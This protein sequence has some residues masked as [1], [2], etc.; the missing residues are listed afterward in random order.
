MQENISSSADAKTAETPSESPVV[1]SP[2]DAKNEGI[3]STADA[4]NSGTDEE[5]HP[6]VRAMMEA[7]GLSID[8]PKEETPAPKVE[9][10][11]PKEEPKEETPKEEQQEQ[12][13]YT[14]SR[15]DVR[16]AEKHKAY[17]ALLGQPIPNDETLLAELQGISKEEKEN[18][19]HEHLRE[20][21]RLRGQRPE[22]AQLDEDDI[23]AIRDEEREAIRREVLAEEEAKRTNAQKA[24][25]ERNFI[26]FIESHPE[27]VKDKKEF[28]ADLYQAVNALFTGGMRIDKAFETVQKQIEIARE[29][30]KKETE[31]R[32]ASGAFSGSQSSGETKTLTWEDVE[33]IQAENPGEYRR[34][35]REGL[36][37]N[38]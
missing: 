38:D 27:L 34:M 3:S 19:L 11:T 35:V 14:P 17:L 2:S 29:K 37:P 26:S 22:T 8:E 30:V 23:E 28:D 16:L 6:K 18:S 4:K 25:E 13:M 15:L 12:P 20:L 31:N 36:L 33:R 32:A 7:Q 5:I 1:P 21:A 10:P 24:E 9:E